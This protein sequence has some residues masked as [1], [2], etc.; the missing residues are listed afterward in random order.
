MQEHIKKQRLQAQVVITSPLTRCLE[1]TAGI[2]GGLW[3]QAPTNGTTPVLMNATSAEEGK[4]VDQGSILQPA[5]PVVACEL[6]R[7][8]L[9]VRRRYAIC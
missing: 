8:T 5:V 1:T 6:C 7:E 2:F 4:S 3:H 9:G